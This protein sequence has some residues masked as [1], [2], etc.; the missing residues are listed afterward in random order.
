MRHNR[1][2]LVAIFLL[3]VLTVGAVS[4]SDTNSTSP[5]LSLPENSIDVIS[6]DDDGDFEDDFDEDD[7]E[8]FEDED[9]DE[10]E[11]EDDGDWEEYTIDWEADS[12]IYYLNNKAPIASMT[13]PED[14]A[15][16][17]EVWKDEKFFANFPL[18][19]GHVEITLGDLDFKNE[20]GHHDLILTYAE[21]DYFVEQYFGTVNVVDYEFTMPQKSVL[22]EEV[23]LIVD[24]HKN[25]SGIIEFSDELMDEFDLEY[26]L[27]RDVP[28]TNGIC[29]ITSS[30]F[31]LGRHYLAFDS[32]D[33][34]IHI[35][36]EF[37]VY[38][39]VTAKNKVVIGQDNIFNLNMAPNASGEITFTL[40]NVEDGS[41]EELTVYY[42]DGELEMNSAGLMSG[43][44]EIT[45]FAII[46]DDLGNFVW[47]ESP[48]YDEEEAFISFEAVYPKNTVIVAKNAVSKY[49][50]GKIYKTR[51]MIGNKAIEGATVVFKIDGKT[52]KTT[53]T[54]ENGFASFKIS[55]V[56]G[57]YK[58]SITALG[59]TVSKKLTVKS[60]VTL[61]KTDVKKSSKKIILT[62]TLAKINGKYLKKKWVT[63][64]FKDIKYKRLTNSKGVAKVT[65]P[66]AAYAYMK[67]GKKVTYQATYMKDTVKRTVMVLN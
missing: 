33:Y 5:D 53:T 58:L 37:W 31:I 36:E 11:D 14:A 1:I 12:A 10:D 41:D 25:V 8:D 18:T 16:E 4:A 20:I 38:P 46:D 9:D 19:K 40:Y 52:V 29:K 26:A 60:I 34:G 35:L 15:G 56:P 22:G 30:D 61:A 42:Q 51:V 39:P 43:H 66:K 13:L 28:I 17:L 7:D 27:Y 32:D 54:D 44:Y 2:L 3:A 63:F 21:G 49:T 45:S 64:K 59:K 55:K 47:E 57:S 23:T 24:L 50:D 62:A 65:I 67:A 48:N 6:D